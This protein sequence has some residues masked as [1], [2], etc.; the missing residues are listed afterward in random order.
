MVDDDAKACGFPN[1]DEGTVNRDTAHEKIGTFCNDKKG[2]KVVVGEP[3]QENYNVGAGVML[4]ITVQ[5]NEVC[6]FDKEQT[7]DQADCDHFLHQ[8]LDDCETSDSNKH[9]GIV[10]DECFKYMLHP[11]DDDGELTC[12]DEREGT[13]INRDEALKNIADFCKKYNGIASSGGQG[14]LLSY[15]QDLGDSQATI[16][17]MYGDAEGCLRGGGPGANYV[18]EERSCVRFLSRTIDA[19]DTDFKGSYGKFGGKVISG[20]GVFKFES[21]V[22]EK[23]GCPDNPDYQPPVT[24]KPEDAERAI[25]SYCNADLTVD[26]NYK[27]DN[28]FHQFQPEGT[29][30][31][32]FVDGL[33]NYVIRM[34]A[35]FLADQSGCHDP[36]KFNTKGDECKRKLKKVIETCMFNPLSKLHGFTNTIVG[37]DKA[38]GFLTDKTNN[39]CVAWMI[40]GQ[41]TSN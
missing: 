29:S 14:N 16:S 34:S 17:V 20:C 19:C 21:Q 27:P 4:N 26:P 37:P 23:S 18:I 13:G 38:G 2:A 10:S 15:W 31:D 40:Y 22:V 1:D 33:D 41:S 24:I 11:E 35:N 30:Y 7:L 32:N 36:V 25:D 39:G 5:Q 28:E 9:G 12:T 3:L 6:S 8:A